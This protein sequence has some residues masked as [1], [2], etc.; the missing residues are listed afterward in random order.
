MLLFDVMLNTQ[1]FTYNLFKQRSTMDRNGGSSNL[2]SLFPC[3]NPIIPRMQELQT[4][5]DTFLT[6]QRSII[7]AQPE[8]LAEAGLF[9]IAERDQVKCW[10]CNGGLQHWEY[11]DDPWFGHAKWYPLCEYLLQKNGPQYVCDITAQFQDLR[12]PSTR[13]PSLREVVS[14]I[15]RCVVNIPLPSWPVTIIDP[16]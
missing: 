8:E 7:Q 11:N 2:E 10:Y 13:N 9:Y 5:V 12:R 4:R 3:R 14:V 1:D 16:R 15:Q 6:W